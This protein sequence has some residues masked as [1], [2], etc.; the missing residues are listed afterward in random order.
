M[1]CKQKYLTIFYTEILEGKIDLQ[2]C[3]IWD[4]IS[5]EFTQQSTMYHNEF[6]SFAGRCPRWDAKFTRYLS[7]KWI[8]RSFEQTFIGIWDSQS[9][10]KMPITTMSDGLQTL[11]A[12]VLL[13]LKNA[14]EL[15]GLL[16]LLQQHWVYF[17]LA[18]NGFA[19]L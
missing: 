8:C 4:L 5:I 3:I 15:I 18:R 10:V 12:D 13:L 11:C 16:L 1:P 2:S 9:K 17:I 14:S 7:N 6:Y 19:K